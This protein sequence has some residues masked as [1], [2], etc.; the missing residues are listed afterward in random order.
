MSQVK[1]KQLLGPTGSNNGSL[2]VYDGGSGLAHWSSDITSGVLL[3]TGNTANR[4]ANP[5]ISMVRFNTDINEAEIYN[6]NGWG[7]I[8]SPTTFSILPDGPGSLQANMGLKVNSAGTSLQYYLISSTFAALSDGPGSLQ[9]DQ[10]IKV[11]SLGSALQYY[12]IVPNTTTFASLVDGP[13]SLQANMGI[14]VNSLGSALQY[15]TMI[16]GITTFASLVDGPGSL[17]ANMAI[18][19]NSLGTSLQYYT[20]TSSFSGLTDG[21]GSLQASLGIKVNSAGTA[22]QYYTI[23]AGISTFTGLTDGPG[24]LQAGMGIAVNTLGTSLTYVPS[25]IKHYRFQANF[26]GQTYPTSV[27]NAPAGWSFAFGGTSSI[28]VTH[29]VGTPLCSITLLCCNPTIDPTLFYQVNTGIQ[30]TSVKLM[31]Y[32][33]SSTFTVQNMTTTTCQTSSSSGYVYVDCYFA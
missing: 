15:Y 27:T 25:P 23:S 29:T 7:P 26:V 6:A 19:V 28:Q 30:G 16:P 21:P 31:W 14:H 9:A 2:V 24:S 12:S 10:G 32:N 33:N 8:G 13:G 1:V 22:L 4:P 20:P 3:P 17:Q 11:N 5:A 18:K